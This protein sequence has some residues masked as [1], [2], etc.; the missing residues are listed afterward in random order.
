MGD[1]VDREV[2]V[3][4]TVTESLAPYEQL[5]PDWAREEMAQLLALALDTH[6]VAATLVDRARPRKA[7]ERSGEQPK[8]ARDA[9]VDLPKRQ[10]GQGGQQ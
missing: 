6:P 5:L 2:F 8:S 7:P 1:A 4:Q 10:G 9:D 3:E